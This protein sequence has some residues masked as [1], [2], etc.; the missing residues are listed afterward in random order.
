M[1]ATP[2]LVISQGK[3]TFS[4]DSVLSS[5]IRTFPLD[6]PPGRILSDSF[7]SRTILPLNTV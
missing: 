5:G 2:L 4:G 7:P 6:I 1:K 3:G